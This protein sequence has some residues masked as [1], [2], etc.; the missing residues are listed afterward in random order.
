MSLPLFWKGFGP[1]LL[2]DLMNKRRT[3]R[4]KLI[5]LTWYKDD[6]PFFIFKLNPLRSNAYGNFLSSS[7]LTNGA[8]Y[9]YEQTPD[10]IDTV[11]VYLPKSST[12]MGGIFKCQVRFAI[13]F[14]PTVLPNSSLP[15]TYELSDSRQKNL[16][17]LSRHDLL[18]SYP[19]TAPTITKE[20][21]E[22]KNGNFLFGDMVK[23]HCVSDIDYT[24][25]RIEW[26]YV[27]NG[28]QLYALKWDQLIPYPNEILQNGFEQSSLGLESALEGHREFICITTYDQGGILQDKP[29]VTKTS[30]KIQYEGITFEDP[31][32]IGLT[33]KGLSENKVLM[34]VIASLVGVILLAISIIICFSVRCYKKNGCQL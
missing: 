20:N 23:L 24:A 9:Y 29:I 25:P 26:L 15:T 1:A 13:I 22:E 6:V 28:G 32:P 21:D 8:S 4:K 19:K 10:Q 3:W 12:Q 2:A 14:D 31:D 5:S 34:I 18:A 33:E 17:I 11:I 16:G 27:G 7:Y 30:Y